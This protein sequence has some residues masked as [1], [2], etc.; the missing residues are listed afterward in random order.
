QEGDEGAEARLLLLDQAY[1]TA[2]TAGESPLTVQQ[3]GALRAAAANQAK[4][5]KNAPPA[6]PSTFVGSWTGLGPDPIVQIARSDNAQITVSGRIGALAFR[7]NGQIIL[8]AA[9]GG[10]WLF[11]DAAGRWVPKTDNL[12]SLA[13]GA[14]AVAPSDDNVVYA[15]TGEGAL[16]G[17]SYYGNGILKSTDGGATWAN[18]SGDYFFG[19]STARLAVDPSDSSHV[20]AAILRGRGGARRVSPPIHSAYGLWESHDGGVSWTLIKPTPAG[21]LGA[22]DVRIDPVDPHVLYAS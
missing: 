11:D 13:I 8:G 20:Y 18:V 16:S 1:I 12:P 15:G 10:I 19:V 7:K 2:R 9:Q 5:L 4:L 6:G 21:T 14:L 17:D 22:T 3:A